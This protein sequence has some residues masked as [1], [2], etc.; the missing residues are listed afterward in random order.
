MEYNGKTYKRS[1]KENVILAGANI[2]GGD[3]VVSLVVNMLPAMRVKSS[4]TITEGDEGFWQDIDLSLLP[5][6]DT[7]LTV[8]YTSVNG[9][10]SVY[11]LNL[12]V[13]GRITTGTDNLENNQPA[14]EK[15][16]RNGQLYI[17][18]NRQIYS[19]QGVKVKTED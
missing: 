6:G 13:L 5:A 4:R 10:D 1:T 14:A 3:S 7:T 2:Y 16:F 18:K 17:R 9:C 15:F 11:V 8:V 19:L 12:Q